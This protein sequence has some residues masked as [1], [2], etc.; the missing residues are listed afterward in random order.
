LLTGQIASVQGNE[1]EEN[2]NTKLNNK[3]KISL[4]TRKKNIN[5]DC[6]NEL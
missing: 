3:I 2:S 1:Q 4:F 5:H 6:H